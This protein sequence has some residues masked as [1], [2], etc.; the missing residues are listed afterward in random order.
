MANLSNRMTAYI[1]PDGYVYDYKEPHIAYIKNQDG[2]TEEFEEH[3]YAKYLYLGKL[4]DI[5]SYKVVKDP[6]K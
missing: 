2:I 3:L 6:R 4:D 5:N 1:A